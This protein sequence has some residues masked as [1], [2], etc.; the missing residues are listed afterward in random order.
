[1]EPIVLYQASLEHSLL[2][3]RGYAVTLVCDHVFSREEKNDFRS[4]CKSFARA[5][6]S[7]RRQFVRNETVEIFS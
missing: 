3:T 6:E 4:T 5:C 1:M 7:Y 2:R